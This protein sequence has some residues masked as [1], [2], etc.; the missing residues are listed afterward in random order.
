MLVGE[1][2]KN[3]LSFGHRIRVQKP[4]N[5]DVYVKAPPFGRD[6]DEVLDESDE[7]DF[8]ARNRIFRLLL[9]PF[10]VVRFDKYKALQSVKPTRRDLG[11][12]ALQK[13]VPPK[14]TLVFCC[15]R[16]IEFLHC[17][18]HCAEGERSVAEKEKG[19]IENLR[20]QPI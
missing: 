15:A 19:K 11:D 8:R 7:H 14:M 2:L 4:A 1:Q 6:S 18:L 5:A 10:K 3:A 17:G 20:R 13:F 16:D 12:L 9:Q